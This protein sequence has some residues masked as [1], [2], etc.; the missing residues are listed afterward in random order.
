MGQARILIL[1]K[2]FQGKLEAELE[3]ISKEDAEL[4]PVGI[5]R[6]GPKPLTP[7]K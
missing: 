6:Q 3:I 7:P 2:L 1:D 4:N 5:G